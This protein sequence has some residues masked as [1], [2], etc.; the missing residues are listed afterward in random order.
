LP[1]PTVGS[2]HANGWGCPRQ[3]LGF[4]FATLTTRKLAKASI[5]HG[6]CSERVCRSRGLSNPQDRPQRSLQRRATIESGVGRRV[7]LSGGISA[8]DRSGSKPQAAQGRGQIGQGPGA[9]KAPGHWCPTYAVVGGSGRVGGSVKFAAEALSKAALWSMPWEPTLRGGPRWLEPQRPRGGLG[10]DYSLVMAVLDGSGARLN[11]DEASR[12]D[13]ARGK[14]EEAFGREDTLSKAAEAFERE[15]ARVSSDKAGSREFARVDS[16][17][18]SGREVPRG[19]S[20]PRGTRARGVASRV[21]RGARAL[22]PT[23]LRR[24]RGARRSGYGR[25]KPRMR[26]R[27]EQGARRRSGR[28]RGGLGASGRSGQLRG[29]FGG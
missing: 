20:R 17:Q 9:L 29:Y 2:A 24:L 22:G 25:G 6:R 19:K 21:F 16:K 1:K 7:R 26:R 28:L 8:P 18:A 15:G 23:L 13:G 5:H 3:R 14:A 10:C 12:R 4:P 27:Y 11:S